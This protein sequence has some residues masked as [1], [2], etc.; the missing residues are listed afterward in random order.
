M[1]IFQPN[2]PMPLYHQKNLPNVY[3]AVWIP[4]R[5]SKQT[6][7]NLDWQSISQLYFLSEN[8]ELL[9]LA[10]DDDIDGI[11]TSVALPS[12]NPQPVTPFGSILHK[13]LSGNILQNQFGSDSF[14]SFGL[15]QNL[16]VKEVS[17]FIFLKLY[18][19]MNQ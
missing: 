7:L 9:Y 10:A 11:A 6:S 12:D 15:T 1:Y 2:V 3:G 5:F 19:S 16:A 8:Q 14:S 13:Q 18:L 17:C 4:R